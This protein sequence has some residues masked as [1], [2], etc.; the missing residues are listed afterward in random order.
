[1]Q[2]IFWQELLSD[3]TLYLLTPQH[4]HFII[5]LYIFNLIF[6]NVNCNFG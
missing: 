5:Q 6:E 2:F 1:M 4:Y 3:M